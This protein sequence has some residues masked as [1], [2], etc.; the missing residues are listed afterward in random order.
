MQIGADQAL[1]S[2]LTRISVSVLGGFFWDTYTQ[3]ERTPDPAEP[4]ILATIG[5]LEA[6]HYFGEG[7]AADVTLPIGTVRYDPG[8]ER[9]A[10]RLSGLG[11]LMLGARYD[12]AA[13]WGAGG[14]NPSVTL[15]AAVGLPSGK[16]ER[17]TAPNVPPNLLAIG[18]ATWSVSGGITLSQFLARWVAIHGWLDALT[19]LG[20]TE[21]GI[22]FGTR[23]GY[24]AGAAFIPVERLALFLDLAGEH[25]LRADEQEE[26]T[27]INSG[28]HLLAAQLS[29]SL[30][31]TDR[32]SLGAGGRLPVYR[33]VGGSQLTETFSVFG[34]VAVSFGGGDEE[35]E[36]H[37]HDHGHDHGHE[38]DE[39]H[40]HAHAS[41]LKS[42]HAPLEDLAEGGASFSL[43]QAPVPGKVTVIDFWAE[44]C[45][46]CKQIGAMLAEMV[47]RT[48]SL[49][50]RR[51]EVPDFDSPV[52]KEHLEGVSALPV[53]W[54]FDAEGN[55]MER[56][57]GV[58][59]DE[60]RA[61]VERALRPK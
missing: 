22:R 56:L 29:V 50:V 7:W 54:I 59:P 31:V 15:R 17:I 38:H 46:P 47:E 60:V 53:I 40:G 26:G 4:S 32:F 19:P 24:G 52:A 44:W 14:Y 1:P 42:T 5:T 57:D 39:P 10:G 51:V 27:I 21:E 23:I 12:L 25:R 35:E 13:L 61:R 20:R 30:A 37:D 58:G 8:L 36:E 34:T 48:P 9:P 18:S 2:N 11:D 3:S 55:L 28:G 45:D 6:R 43:E 33:H 49:A 41:E 16:Q